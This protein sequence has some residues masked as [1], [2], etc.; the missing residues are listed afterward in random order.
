MIRLPIEGDDLVPAPD[1]PAG[2]IPEWLVGKLFDLIGAALSIIPVP[3]GVSDMTSGFATNIA[4]LVG[5]AASIGSWVP[6]GSFAAAL[7]FAGTSVGLA[8]MIKLG[9]IVAS[10]FTAGGGSAG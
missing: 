2:S 8:F 10:F 4:S 3:Q 5:M 7:T 9:R 1:V 6:W